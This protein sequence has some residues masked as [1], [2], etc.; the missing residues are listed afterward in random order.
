MGAGQA[1]AIAQTLIA[2]G[3]P[4]HTPVVVVRDAS[5]ASSTTRTG[6]LGDLARLCAGQ[7]AEG[8]ADGM[9]GAAVILL[10][11]AM[12]EVVAA[13]KFPQCRS[14]AITQQHH[15]RLAG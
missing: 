5:L 13:S 7:A 9:A 12:R 4:A 2:R 6:T 3:R 14:E 15:R 1:E 8:A 10:G 11:E